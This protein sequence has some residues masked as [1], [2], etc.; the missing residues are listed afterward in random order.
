ME[1]E[2]LEKIMREN[3]LLNTIG[4]G[5]S[6]S[7]YYKSSSDRKAA[8]I[9]RRADLIGQ[10]D[11]CRKVATWL[12]QCTKAEARI[13]RKCG[14]YTWKHIVEK[15]LGTYVSNGAFIAAAIYCGYKCEPIKED[16]N[17]NAYFNIATHHSMQ[18]QRPPVPVF[19]R[20]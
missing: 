20:L 5:M 10:L 1:L 4:F 3:P 11:T 18:R 12:K 9:K 19:P 16:E 7:T 15:E 2:D 17:P 6:T 8:V 13:N 14:S